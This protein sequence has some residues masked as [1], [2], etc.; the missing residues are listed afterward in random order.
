MRYVNLDNQLAGYEERPVRFQ[1][2]HTLDLLLEA[3]Q[4]LPERV[5]QLVEP[6]LAGIYLVDG[7]GSSGY[8]ESIQGEQGRPVAGVIILDAALFKRNA[9]E[10]ASW[11]DSTAFRFNPD[12]QI[13][14]T[15]ASDANNSLLTAI[16]FLVVHEM[17]HVYSIGT[18]VHPHWTA[19]LQQVDLADFPFAAT[20]WNISPAGRYQSLFDAAFWQRSKLVY[21]Q[22]PGL[23]ASEIVPVLGNLARTNFPSLYA[24][25]R[26]EEDF[27]ETFAIYVISEMMGNPYYIEAR[28]NGETLAR[29]ESCFVT[30]CPR[31]RAFMQRLL[32]P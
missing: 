28:Q 2:S 31:K 17:A 23:D 3:Y 1:D 24:S 7:L 4:S 30:R 22:T 21:Y 18:S 29:V 15:I 26:P 19:D 25:T 8:T 9:N 27:A 10:W 32:E 20:S 14:T 5:R 13:R 12:L 6:K 11:R 16:Q